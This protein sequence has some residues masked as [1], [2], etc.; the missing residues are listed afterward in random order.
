M[1]LS[2]FIFYMPKI[3]YFS[4]IKKFLDNHLST[5][6]PSLKKK[7]KTQIN[8]TPPYNS[9]STSW[10]SNF[11]RCF[12]RK[13]SEGAV[14]AGGS[15]WLPLSERCNAQVPA[16]QA[17]CRT[18]WPN[19]TQINSHAFHLILFIISEVTLFSFFRLQVHRTVK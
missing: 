4:L 9:L 18:Q 8:Q 16:Q 15:L 5:S 14:G 11:I 17:Q 7:K 10:E 3:L 19:T 13:S 12:T 2:N 6:P 1:T